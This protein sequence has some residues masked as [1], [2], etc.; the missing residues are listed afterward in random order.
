VPRRIVHRPAPLWKW[1]GQHLVLYMYQI[2][3]EK[4]RKQYR[5]IGHIRAKIRLI[6][7]KFR[8]LKVL[9]EQ[10]ARL[11]HASCIASG[12]GNKNRNEPNRTDWK[13]TQCNSNGRCV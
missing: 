11:A 4:L 3:A 1:K 8:A 5:T 6:L 13:D 9:N 12:N 10:I 7:E 2:Q